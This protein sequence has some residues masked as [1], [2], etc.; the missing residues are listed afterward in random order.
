VVY[1][2][3]ADTEPVWTVRRN[4][5]TGPAQLA[6]TGAGGPGDFRTLAA[7]TQSQQPLPAKSG[8]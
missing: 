3:G 2:G 7:A 4:G 1:A 5:P 6:I 8:I